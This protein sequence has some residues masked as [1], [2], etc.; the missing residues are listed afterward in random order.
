MTRHLR[1]IIALLLG[2]FLAISCDLTDT[3]HLDRPPILKAYQPNAKEID[4]FL[5]DTLYFNISATD[6][7]GAE[8]QHCFMMNDSVVS[9]SNTWMYVVCDTG[10]VT[11]KGMATDG[12]VS[13]EIFWLMNRHQPENLPPVIR[14]FEPPDLNPVMIIGHQVDFRLVAED[15][16]NLP[17]SYFYKIAD[18]LVSTSRHY[19]FLATRFGETEITAYATDGEKFNWVR[20]LVKV[21]DYPDT[22]APA[23]VE[24]V[25]LETGVE[26]GEIYIRWIAVG[27]DGMQGLPSYYQ[28]R[29][30]KTPIV[31]EYTWQRSSDRPGEPSPAPAWQFQQ[32]MIRDLNPADSVY[33][34]IRAVD[35]FSNISPLS[36]PRR[37]KAKGQEL[38]GSVRNSITNEPIPGVRLT[39]GK[40]EA[41]TESDGRYAF[42]ALPFFTGTVIVQD[43]VNPLACGGY[44]DLH[45]Y[46]TV[47]H[48]DTVNIWLIPNYDLETEIYDD[49]LLFFRHMTDTYNN[50]Y[51]NILRT[52][53][54]PFDFYI[55]PYVHNE[56]DYAATIANVL[57]E[58]EAITGMDLFNIVDSPPDVGVRVNYQSDLYA[59]NYHVEER[60]VDTRV[61]I[62]GLITFR[63]VYT[64]ATKSV[65]E[66][67]IRHEVGHAFGMKHSADRA[68]L[69]YGGVDINPG[70]SHMTSDELAILFSMYHIPRFFL[71][72]NYKEN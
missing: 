46:Y 16:E 7:D 29:T 33:V 65:F 50:I 31:D 64:P 67:I 54:L 30:S 72:T 28:V 37:A 66:K 26:P 2:I 6:P 38:F 24:I 8:L 12:G 4:T 52:W 11:V 49:F 53:E 69:M 1:Y 27:E 48:E 59:D 23:K 61:P 21:T 68:H 20:W 39:I 42:H 71:I 9:N 55:Q 47:Q 40:E 25:D 15:P 51:S 58:Y 62:K 19:S 3:S 60:S 17:I 57:D 10:L 5:G 32:M 14:S 36:D 13:L 63:T 41:V 22:I 45:F 18:S 34:A 70:V 56:L 35:E 44:F 43:E